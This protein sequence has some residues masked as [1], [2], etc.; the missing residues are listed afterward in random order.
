MKPL[1]LFLLLSLSSFIFS[2]VDPSSNQNFLLIYPRINLQ[3]NVLQ[4]VHLQ[5][6]SDKTDHFLGNSFSAGLEVASCLNENFYYGIGVA[7][8]FK[9]SIDTTLGDLGLLPIYLFIDYPLIERNSFPI[10][11]TVQFGYGLL[12]LENGL[13]SINS[14]IFHALG[15]TTSISKN[16]ELKL[17]YAYNY[18]RVKLDNDEFRL[19]KENLSIAFYYK[20]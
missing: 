14:G 17:L 8:Q 19:R 6:E 16:V 1:S 15:L 18:G 12:I 11:L 5:S 9:G 20:F 13:K 2:Q 4:T 10:Y 3:A 7:Y